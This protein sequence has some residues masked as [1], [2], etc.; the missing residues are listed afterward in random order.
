MKHVPPL[1]VIFTDSRRMA[2]G[3]TST[4]SSHDDGSSAHHSTSSTSHG[5]KKV[6]DRFSKGILRQSR[7]VCFSTFLIYFLFLWVL[8]FLKE[9]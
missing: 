2:V 3:C 4:T 8:K 7:C 1:R 9:T 6:E 5:S